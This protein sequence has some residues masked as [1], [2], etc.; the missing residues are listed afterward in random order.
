MLTSAQMR[1][2]LP[3]QVRPGLSPAHI[4]IITT[5]IVSHQNLGR[6]DNIRRRIR[7]HDEGAENG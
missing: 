4:I 2:E 7:P 5:V 3:M 6:N 1:F